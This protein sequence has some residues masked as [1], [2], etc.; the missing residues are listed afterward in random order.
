[1]GDDGP[2]HAS[3]Y[4]KELAKTVHELTE[5]HKAIE[6]ATKPTKSMLEEAA[7]SPYPSDAAISAMAEQLYAQEEEEEEHQ[8]VYAASEAGSDEDIK[9]A[10]GISVLMGQKNPNPY[11]VD[12]QEL[13][14]EHDKMAQEL[15]NQVAKLTAEEVAEDVKKGL[16]AHV[17]TP[18]EENPFVHFSVQDRPKGGKKPPMEPLDLGDFERH[19]VGVSMRK[20]GSQIQWLSFPNKLGARVAPYDHSQHFIVAPTRRSQKHNGWEHVDIPILR[21][22][23]TAVKRPEALVIL[24]RIANLPEPLAKQYRR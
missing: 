7:V 10:K 18:V 11:D 21:V 14:G 4:L 24:Q 1:M 19:K 8:K 3:V 13:F 23:Y 15:A 17:Q 16:M 12:T 6:K 22:P 5:M 9:Y 20:D 2:T